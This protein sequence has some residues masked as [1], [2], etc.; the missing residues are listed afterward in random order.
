[1]G[2]Q[3][4]DFLSVDRGQ[5]T[6]ESG[7]GNDTYQLTLN[8]AGSQINDTV[9][10]DRLTIA[11]GDRNLTISLNQPTPGT[12]GLYKQGN[13]LIVDLNSDGAINRQQDLTMTNFFNGTAMGAGAIE[14]INDLTGSA[15]AN[16]FAANPLPAN[17]AVYSFFRSDLNTYF[18]TTS[19]QE[20]EAIIKRLPN[21]DY[22]GESFTTSDVV[23]GAKPVYR[24][25]NR[26]T[27]AHF[28]TISETEKN[29]IADNLNNYSYEDVAYHAYD[30]QQ[31]N[32]I[33]LYRFYN[34]ADDCHVYTTSTEEQDLMLDNAS[35]FRP[36]GDNGI[37]FYVESFT[38]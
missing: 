8:S 25:L 16:Y 1:M 5:S 26:N 24:F 22:V 28:Y 23:T 10:T 9:G 18:H 15:I 4:D 19:V 14:Q 3:G 12:F 32:A 21:F 31:E 29:Y 2:F 37:A 7:S 33:E 17:P 34:L 11:D 36:E 20:K 38:I 30:T 6:L 35:Q 13:D 27:G